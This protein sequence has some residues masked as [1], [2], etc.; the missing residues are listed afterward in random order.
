M[1][2]LVDLCSLA[3]FLRELE[4]RLKEVHEQPGGGIELRKR[5]SRCETFKTSVADEPPDYRAILLLDE[6]LIVLPIRATAG[7]DNAVRSAI[8]YRPRFLRHRIEAYAARAAG[9]SCLA[10]MAAG[11]RKPCRSISQVAL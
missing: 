9:G 7:E 6:C 10:R 5:D 4:R 11:G 8:L 3:A 1:V 2:A